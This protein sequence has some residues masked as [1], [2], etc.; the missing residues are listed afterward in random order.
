MRDPKTDTTGC[1]RILSARRGSLR[2]SHLPISLGEDGDRS[3][4]RLSN[5]RHGSIW[6]DPRLPGEEGY[7]FDR[8]LR[9]A[10]SLE[11]SR[12]R[13]SQSFALLQRTLPYYD[14]DV[15]VVGGKNSAAEVALDLW[16]HGARVTLVHRDEKPSPS[17]KYWVRPDLENRIKN[18]EIAA[19]FKSSVQE[20]GADLVVL[21][22]P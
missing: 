21:K 6:Q 11:C 15:V 16:R 22:T 10:K 8:L 4:R 19:Y 17:V 3:R 5:Y 12:R 14:S 1:A 18:H 9:S 13:T 20:I 7:C 2:T